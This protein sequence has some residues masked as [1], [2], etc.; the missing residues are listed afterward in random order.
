MKSKDNAGSESYASASFV[1]MN[2]FI[3]TVTRAHRI[4]WS[5]ALPDGINPRLNLLRRSS[6][7][8]FCHKPSRTFF[9]PRKMNAFGFSEHSGK[10]PHIIGK[11]RHRDL[12][13]GSPFQNPTY[14][15]T[16][17]HLDKPTL[18]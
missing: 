8:E 12:V 14:L 10:F 6:R 7:V 4:C 15:R 1:F 11:P 9:D 17:A 13:R 3:D 2:H 16:G 5:A 18:C